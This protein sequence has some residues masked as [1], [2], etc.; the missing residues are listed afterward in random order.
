MHYYSSKVSVKAFIMLQK[1]Y[2]SNKYFLFKGKKCFLSS[3]SAYQ[4]DFWRIIWHWKQVMMLKIKLWHQRNKLHF[5]IYQNRKQLFKILTKL[6]FFTIFLINKC[7]LGE[8]KRLLYIIANNK[9]FKIYSEN[10]NCIM[11]YHLQFICFFC[12][13]CFLIETCLAWAIIVIYYYF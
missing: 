4:N 13:F 9:T 6:L 12:V 5:K 3:K 7:I 11:Y 1:I 8:H 2:I 10:I